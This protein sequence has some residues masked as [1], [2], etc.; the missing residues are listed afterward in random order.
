MMIQWIA[1]PGQTAHQGKSFHL[2]EHNSKSPYLLKLVKPFRYG[3][4]SVSADP[5]LRIS[6]LTELPRVNAK[7]VLGH[8]QCYNVCGFNQSLG[9][10]KMMMNVKHNKPNTA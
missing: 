5:G 2:R 9:A 1:I 3:S 8:L 10:G 7:Q 4:C 6:C